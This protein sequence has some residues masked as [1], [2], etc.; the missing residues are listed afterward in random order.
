MLSQLKFH[1]LRYRLGLATCSEL[2]Q[3]ADAALNAEIY[4]P[5]LVDAALDAEECLWEIGAA[6]EQALDELGLMLSE[7]RHEC[8][9]EVLRYCITQIANQGIEPLTGLNG[10]MEVYRGCQLY[11]QSRHYVGDSHDIHELVGAYWSYGELLERPEEIT[12]D[13]LAGEEA[14]LALNADVI[15]MCKVWLGKH[16]V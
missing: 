1:G 8:C 3:T 9:W 4:S 10:V 12:H 13:G 6:F 7:T 15:E 11:G 14:I 2:R 16:A 5:S